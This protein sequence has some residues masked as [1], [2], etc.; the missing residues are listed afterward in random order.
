MRT[1]RDALIGTW[2]ECLNELRRVLSQLDETSAPADVG[3]HID[4]GICRLEEVVSDLLNAGNS[5]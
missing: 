3:A 5:A 2:R 4:C 1:E